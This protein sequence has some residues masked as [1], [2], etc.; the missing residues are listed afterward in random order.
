MVKKAVRIRCRA[1]IQELDKKSIVIKDVPY[2][3]TT[4]QLM[5]SIVKANDQ[6]K[7]KIK[8]VTDNTA[9]DVEVVIEL[10]AGISSD[11][12]IDALYAFT[13]CEVSIAPNSC[14][15][16][17]HKPIFGSVT[18][19]LQHST[20]YTKELLKKELRD[21]IGRIARKMALYLFGKNIL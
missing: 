19:L 8:K 10:A 21:S 7:I 12:T 4:T 3:V 16:I 13:D 5:E 2:G 18:A 17:D 9:A 1:H 6:G 15:I 14:V 11:I 20:D